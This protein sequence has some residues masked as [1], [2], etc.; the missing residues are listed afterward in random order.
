MIKCYGRLRGLILRSQLIVLLQNKVFNEYTDRWEG[1]LSIKMFR[2]EY[3]RY[4]TIEKVN[5]S[6]EEKTFTLDLRPFMNPT[7]YTLKHVSFFNDKAL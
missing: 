7:P 3:P 4:P 2:D 1:D 6:E 5:I